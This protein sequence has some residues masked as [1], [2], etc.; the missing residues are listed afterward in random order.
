MGVER[1]SERNMRFPSSDEN[2]SETKDIVTCDN[3]QPSTVYTIK[4]KH[5]NK[6][7][8]RREEQE[9]KRKEAVQASNKLTQ[10]LVDHLNVGVAQAYLNQKRLDTEASQLEQNATQFQ[11]A[12]N[13]WLGLVSSFASALKEV[14]HVQNWSNTIHKDMEEISKTLEIAY[15]T[16]WR[17]NQNL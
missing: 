12:T 13:Q 4:R 7:Q 2:G 15:K 8:I 14:G 6:Q 11:K 9:Q 10:A 1:P 16:R 5:Q 3:N 17:E